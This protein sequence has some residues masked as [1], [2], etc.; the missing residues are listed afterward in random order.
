MASQ[1]DEKSSGTTPPQGQKYNGYE[2]DKDWNPKMEDVDVSSREVNFGTAVSRFDS[3]R[4]DPVTDLRA[5]LSTWG[6][7]CYM[8]ERWPINN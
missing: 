5:R 8:E 7:I 3:N 6:T 4:S 2:D 1:Y